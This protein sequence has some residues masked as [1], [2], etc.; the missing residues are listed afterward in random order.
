MSDRI[1][2]RW[3]VVA[4]VAAGLP[5]GIATA[6]PDP[7]EF[8][9]T[10]RM[11]PFTST[12]HYATSQTAGSY[13]V[14]AADLDGDG[15]QELVAATSTSSPIDGN[16]V[17]TMSIHP[18]R[19]G[20]PR[21]SPLPPEA[22]GVLAMDLGDW[23]QDGLLDIV[24][25][26]L[27]DEFHFLR[28]RGDGTFE[29]IS[30]HPLFDGFG[31]IDTT[32][33]LVEGSSVAGASATVLGGHDAA[34][35]AYH[36]DTAGTVLETE[37][38]VEGPAGANFFI[39]DA[40]DDGRDDLIVAG[41]FQMA[42]TLLLRQADQTWAEPIEI[43]GLDATRFT[44]AKV[45]DVN[46]DGHDDLVMCV[47]SNQ[48][49]EQI[50]TVLNDPLGTTG[51]VI[52][53]GFHDPFTGWSWITLGDFD[54]D[55]I[56]DAATSE[57]SFS[58]PNS[59]LWIHRG[60]GTGAFETVQTAA[61]LGSSGP[62]TAVP[63]MGGR[64]AGI[65]ISQAYPNAFGAQPMTLLRGH[66]GVMP[67][68]TVVG[69]AREYFAV[70]GPPEDRVIFTMDPNGFTSLRP[71][72]DRRLE[73]RDG[74]WVTPIYELYAIAG[75]GPDAEGRPGAMVLARRSS[76]F[77]WM[78]IE[79]REGPDGPIEVA[80]ERILTPGGP[81]R[82]VIISRDDGAEDGVVLASGDQGD[83]EIFLG[84]Y[85]RVE[86]IWTLVDEGS[87]DLSGGVAPGPEVVLFPGDFNGDG[88]LDLA[89]GFAEDENF[90]PVTPR[91]LGVIFDVETEFSDVVRFIPGPTNEQER[92]VTAAGDW[93][94]DGRSDLVSLIYEV[95][96]PAPRRLSVTRFNDAGDPITDT[97]SLANDPGLFEDDGLGRMPRRAGMVS[98]DA[99]PRL[100][101]VR[102]G[103]EFNPTEPTADMIG[104]SGP[105][106]ARAHRFT[107]GHLDP[108]APITFSDLDA[109]GRDDLLLLTDRR[110]IVWFPA[111]AWTPDCRT[112]LDG[113]GLV[114]FD[115]L[116]TLLLDIGITSDDRFR[117]RSDFN[118]DGLV[119]F[120]DLIEL[121]I[122]WG[123]C[124]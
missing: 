106:T 82:L 33:R 80:A 111:A 1:S 77:H 88:R 53:S 98:T 3:L 52:A 100:V 28:G 85:E 107:V 26:D 46:G 49:T 6:G 63:P 13:E 50:R 19:L 109:D 11:V 22:A 112:D 10:G 122:T 24:V 96:V 47:G 37:T 105:G 39:W 121:I 124:S 41:T 97:R 61:N 68:D 43:P 72:P 91:D 113:N 55:G 62:I 71:T 103:S 23:D 35:V 45:A 9:A 89:G 34:L 25:H 73:A 48:A 95:A 38:L 70:G 15:R 17:M 36:V 5:A 32:I 110:R 58:D 83:S 54:G 108:D 118:E 44:E 8:L 7:V 56:L 94:G 93:D 79:L 119:D 64:P 51:A 60:D 102:G 69:K 81:N 84:R 14:L 86:G 21:F 92:V 115:D 76:P 27:A 66:E 12:T 123:P 29:S 18:T 67:G 30:S 31:D 104:E 87:I 40:N 4:V 116:L 42:P 78:M 75:I 74:V 90:L 16:A 114:G 101:V 65:V 99:G 59:Y 20:A 120:L 2:H 117:E 57:P